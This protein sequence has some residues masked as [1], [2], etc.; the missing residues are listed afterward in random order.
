MTPKYVT[1]L[2]RKSNRQA[3]AQEGAGENCSR[4]LT[5]RSCPTGDSGWELPVIKRIVREAK[6]DS[7]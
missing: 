2:R 6:D 4:S 7:T 5:D 3:G 1:L